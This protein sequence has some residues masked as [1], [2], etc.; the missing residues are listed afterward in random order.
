[1]L[2]ILGK[3]LLTLLGLGLIVGTIV[4]IFAINIM[5]LQAAA[6]MMV[7]PPETIATDSVKKLEWRRESKAVGSIEAVQGV[8]LSNEFSGLVS[9]INFKS[10]Q[11]VQAGTPLV[12][13]NRETE[14][15]QLAAAKATE[16]LAKLNLKRARE[17]FEK[18]TISKAELDLAVAEESS[19]KAQVNNL[20]A[21]I[22]RRT[23][24]APF[25]GKLGI[26][27]ID[28]GEYLNT[29]A[30]IVTLQSQDPVYASFFL[31]QRELAEISEGLTVIATTDAAPEVE[32]TGKI[33][34]IE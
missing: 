29:G 9:K 22:A 2:K 15:A 20:D 12:E 5:A 23:I 3:L 25:S 21:V 26:R 19:A 11:S 7:P 18:D 13:L 31:P 32:F 34:A 14:E 6:P 27:Q 1:M 17:L 33:T 28:L 24:Y 16:N 8:V 10:G 30:P 4:G